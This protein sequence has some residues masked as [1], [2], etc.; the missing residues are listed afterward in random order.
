MNC[1]DIGVGLSLSLGLHLPLFILF[2]PLL[3][4]LDW[5]RAIAG[6]MEFEHGSQTGEV[7]AF[8]SS[9]G[10]SPSRWGS[11][12]VF[13][14][15]DPFHHNSPMQKDHVQNKSCGGKKTVLL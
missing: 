4:G 15:C 3:K 1:G 9:L 11:V 14:C 13:L 6:A 12:I 5:V 8:C 10:S 7:E 2:W